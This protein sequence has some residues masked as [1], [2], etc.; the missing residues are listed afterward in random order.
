MNTVT[1]KKSL[2]IATGKT[3][4]AENTRLN[5]YVELTKLRISI[6]VLITFLVAGVL[7]AHATA[8]PLSLFLLANAVAGMFM[9]AASGNA[10]NMYL[11][12]YSDF[13]MPRTAQRPLPAQKLSAMEVATFAAVTFS[14]GVVILFQLVNW[15]TAVAGIVNWVLYSFVYTPLKTKHWSNTEIGAIAGAMPI[16]MGSLATTG[17]VGLIGWVFFA[18]LF[19]W[20]FPHFMAI[21]WKYRHQYR[22]GG[23][24]MLTVTEPTGS[25]AGQKA[26]VTA[27][28]L[29]L[30][31]LIP[32]IEVRTI[33]H[34]IL[35][36]LPTLYLGLHYLRA[37]WSFYADRND[38]TARSLMKSSLLYLPFY[39]VTMIVCLLT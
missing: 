3:A 20:Q 14:I 9:I 23:L 28:L 30:V 35:F 7:A 17:S 31:S 2:D 39:M 15:Q 13:L 16:V 29:I 25:A 22:N 32:I 21:A 38:S 34:A 26:V 10:M 12:R 1:N 11:E 5:A 18:V 6:M 19:L 8:V 37:S 4:A 27:A 33:G 24:K 36:A